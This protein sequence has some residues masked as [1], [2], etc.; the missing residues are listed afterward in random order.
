MRSIVDDQGKVRATHGL[1]TIMLSTQQNTSAKFHSHPSGTRNEITRSGIG[2]TINTFFF[3]Q[4]PSPDDIINAGSITNYVFG[5]ADGM[6]Y[7]YNAQGVQAVINY[8]NF[9]NFDK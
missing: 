6:V 3:T 1:A 9:I 2:I 7:I 8:K 5:R 4:S